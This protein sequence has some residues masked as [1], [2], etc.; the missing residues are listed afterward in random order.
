MGFNKR[1]ADGEAE[2]GALLFRCISG[3]DLL[4][5]IEHLALHWQ[6]YA[7]TVVDYFD[8]GGVG[9][10]LIGK[11]YLTAWTGE[12]DGVGEKIG[13]YL[14]QSVRIAVYLCVVIIIWNCDGNVIAVG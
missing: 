6:G 3:I 10:I 12:L 14:R 13:N 2:T 4:E 8:D 9:L 5:S 11:R 7:T 1:F